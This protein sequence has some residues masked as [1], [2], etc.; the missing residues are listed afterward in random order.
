[1]FS[2]GMPNVASVF[3]YLR[4]LHSTATCDHP[5]FSAAGNDPKIFHAVCGCF[6]LSVSRL[7]F[8]L[9]C[10]LRVLVWCVT[11]RVYASQ[12]RRITVRNKPDK[13][14]VSQ[15]QLTVLITV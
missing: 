12:S 13:S 2:L 3:A 8:S 5:A 1:M 4:Y 6:L 14:A 15:Q 11:Y 10:R 7:M 9:V